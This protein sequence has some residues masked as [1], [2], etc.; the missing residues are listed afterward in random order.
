MLWMEVEDLEPERQYQFWVTA[1]TTAGEGMRSDIVLQ[2][3]S[4]RGN[5]VMM[6]DVSGIILLQSLVFVLMCFL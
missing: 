3:P 4:M 2:T 5:S 1:V 6:M